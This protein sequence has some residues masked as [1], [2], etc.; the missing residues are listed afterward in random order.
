MND[1]II[2]FFEQ[3]GPLTVAEAMDRGIA[4]LCNTCF[5]R[6]VQDRLN[7]LVGSGELTRHTERR[8][9]TGGIGRYTGSNNIFVYE[10]AA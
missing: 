9:R 4:T 10:V 2:A 7:G 6:T 5:R 8:K 1:A 3:H